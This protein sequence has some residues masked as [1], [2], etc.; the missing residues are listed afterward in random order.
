MQLRRFKEQFQ[1]NIFSAHRR[2]MSKPEACK[3]RQDVKRPTTTCLYV[4]QR[5]QQEIL[6]PRRVALFSRA[7]SFVNAEFPA[8]PVHL[9]LFFLS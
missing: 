3:Y 8:F 6:D 2:K 4:S 9:D 5:D 7:A 1:S